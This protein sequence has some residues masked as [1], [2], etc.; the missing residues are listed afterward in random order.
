M[1]QV[2]APRREALVIWQWSTEFPAVPVQYATDRARLP[3]SAI[4]APVVFGERLVGVLAVESYQANGYDGHDR[5]AAR[6]GG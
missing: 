1:R 4:I 5:W 3:E 2:S 6:A